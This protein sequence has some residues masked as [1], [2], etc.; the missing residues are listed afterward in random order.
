[1]SGVWSGVAEGDR[2]FIKG[3]LWGSIVAGRFAGSPAALYE[4]RVDGDMIG[5]T[6]WVGND[7]IE[8]LH[9]GAG[10]ELSSGS[11]KEDDRG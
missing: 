7:N 2:V 4:V 3:G 9:R 6:R 1:M 5:E 8:R 10:E 11:D